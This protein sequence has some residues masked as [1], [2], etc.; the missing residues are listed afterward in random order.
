L[1]SVVL[2][3]VNTLA[4]SES[5]QLQPRYYPKS[6]LSLLLL[7]FVLA[8]LPI[9]V[10]LLQA[11]S[12]ID[13]FARQSRS[14][15][16]ETSKAAHA[17][18]QLYEEATGLERLARQMLILRD[19]DVLD[20]YETVRKRFKASSSELSLL[21]LDE[22]QL[23]LL[24]KVIDTEQSLF[25]K[26]RQRAGEPSI[27]AAD[28][29]VLAEDY[30]ALSVLAREMVDVSDELIG[31]GL[32]ALQEGADE[33]QRRLWV[34]LP[35]ML[36]LGIG[37][38]LLAIL[39]IARPIRELD[40]AIRRLGG[41]DLVPTIQIH[42][43]GDFER[44]GQRLD[45]L[46]LRLIELE[47]QKSRFLRHVSHELKT[48]LTA[49]REGASLLADGTVGPLN[50]EQHEVVDILQNKSL[51]LQALIERLLAVQREM[52]GLGRLLPESVHLSLL[53]NKVLDEHR[54]PLTARNIK[55]RLD[56]SPVRVIGDA[57]KLA[58]VLDN[59][60]SNALRHSPEGAI[61]DLR[62]Y[63]Q[64]E[65]ANVEVRDQG[66]GIASADRENIFDWFYQGDAPPGDQIAGSGFGLAIAREYAQAH[67]GSLNLLPEEGSGAAFRLS[68]PLAYKGN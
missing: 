33:T 67:H 14:V 23:T 24:N 8:V 10:A 2:L 59:L 29:A 1:L 45:W 54:L 17:S 5:H 41:G 63:R 34:F 19:T 13:H 22:R 50:A 44:L 28:R 49:M 64:G 58:T 47:A 15:V 18:R 26:L 3:G 43:P 52:E 36:A 30:A 68:L 62:L 55:I 27:P 60:V 9:A 11:M 53:L 48:P 61:I 56:V 20:D 35:A 12:G 25:E 51:Q 6:F 31:R 37:V 42:G 7:A 32:I 16:G 46:R 40:D 39:L 4:S 57:A 66:P 21:P 65:T 38:A